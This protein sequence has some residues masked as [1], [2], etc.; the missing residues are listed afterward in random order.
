MPPY[1]RRAAPTITSVLFDFDGT[2]VHT[3]PGVLLG[4]RTVFA[5]AGITPVES[6]DERVIGPPLAATL[7][8]L[9]GTDDP[10]TIARLARDFAAIYD[11]EGVLNADPY[12]GLDN[13]LAT[14][15][16]AG[17]RSFIV[18]NKRQVP[19]RAIADRLGILRQFV[20]LYS[21]DSIIPPAPSKEAMVARLLADHAIEPR[22]TV[23]VGDSHEDA[24]A[25][26]AHG[27]RFIAATYGYGSPLS[28]T[29]VTPAATLNRIADLPAV[30]AQL[31]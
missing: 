20:A 30:L 18:T 7:T 22:H 16:A 10:V 28:A 8:R 4:F 9:A 25:A 26:A 13:V 5:D 11:S 12:P 15:S 6:V 1:I 14:L 17:R 29:G 24:T 23:L 3:A 27:I 21:R 31:E 19:A 2:L